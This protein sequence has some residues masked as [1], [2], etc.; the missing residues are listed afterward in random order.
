[1]TDYMKA[2]KLL[3]CLA[4]IHRPAALLNVDDILSKTTPEELD[5]FYRW[6]CCR[7]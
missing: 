7:V 4:S 3:A 6:C 1:M 5:F 2:M